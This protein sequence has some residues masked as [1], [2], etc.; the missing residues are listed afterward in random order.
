MRTAVQSG[1][2]YVVVAAALCLAAL[3]AAAQDPNP[4]T[5]GD[6]WHFTVAP[7]LW[8]SSLDGAVSFEGTPEVPVDASFSDILENL[9]VAAS[10]HFEGRNGRWGF[11]FDGMYVKLGAQASFELPVRPPGV[12]M[13]GEVALEVK[14]TLVEGFGFYRLAVGQRPTNPGFADAFV[15]FRHVDTTQH[16]TTARVDLPRR[17]LGWTDA[18]FGVRGYAP[19]GDRFGFLARGDMAAGS[20]FTWSLKGDLHWLISDR[21]R[22]IAGYRHMDPDYEKGEGLDREVY[23]LKHSGPELA[24]SFSW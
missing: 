18:L 19:L 10:L 7:Y 9:D 2:L 20:S 8:A 5:A 17:E 24:V 4:A 6:G 21:W 1:R 3:P 23:T 16:V 11:A 13:S 15:G 12:T 22:L 14:E